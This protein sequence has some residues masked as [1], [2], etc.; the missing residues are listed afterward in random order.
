MKNVWVV[1]ASQNWDEITYAFVM[2]AASQTQARVTH[3]QMV[4][5]ASRTQV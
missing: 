5:V 3:A 1:C 2:A 4:P